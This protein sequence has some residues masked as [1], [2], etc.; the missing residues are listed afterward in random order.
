ML[1]YKRVLRPFSVV[2]QQIRQV[3]TLRS[4]HNSHQCVPLTSCGWEVERSHLLCCPG[5]FLRGGAGVQRL[6]RSFPS[7]KELGVLVKF[8]I[9]NDKCGLGLIDQ[10]GTYLKLIT[11]KATVRKTLKQISISTVPCRAQQD[12][13]R[14]HRQA[15]EPSYNQILPQLKK[16]FK[17]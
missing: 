11:Q 8:Q 12:L 5:H 2:K 14:V 15:Q 13:L 3:G 9:F 4:G 6:S 7:D 1:S 17:E 10:V 16:S